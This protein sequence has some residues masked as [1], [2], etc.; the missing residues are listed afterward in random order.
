MTGVN[1]RVNA[2]TRP[3]QAELGRLN[4]SLGNLEAQASKIQKTFRN[5]GLAI[6]GAFAATQL[7]RGL[8]SAADSITNLNNRLALVVGKGDAAAKTL[9][10]LF[11]V[12]ADTRSSIDQSAETFQR[13]GLALKDA[14]KNSDDFLKITKL[15]NQ[16]AIL[17][18]TGPESAKAAIIQLGQGLASG[19]LRGQELNSVLE[20]TPRL[21][22]AIADGMGIPFGSL[23]Q[24]AED[25]LLTTQTVFDAIIDQSQTLGDEFKLMNAT[26]GDLTT[27]LGNE[28]T[29]A[30]AKV[31]GV[32]GF[33]DRAKE[34]IINLTTAFRFVGKNVDRFALNV[35]LAYLIV[36]SQTL[37]LVHNIK[38]AFKGLFSTN[39]DAKQFVDNLLSS[40]TGAAAKVSQNIK[41][42]FTLESIA[43][44]INFVTE[45]FDLISNMFPSGDGS[46]LTTLQTFAQN[47]IDI[48]T[49]LW[50]AIV[51]DSWWTGIFDPAHEENGKAAIGNVASWGKNLDKARNYIAGWGVALTKVFKDLWSSI[52]FWYGTSVDYVKNLTFG[53]VKTPDAKGAFETL[54]NDVSA[55]W[56][57]TLNYVNNG[58]FEI[59]VPP[60]FGT[61]VKT[62]FDKVIADMITKWD[63]FAIYIGAETNLHVP[64]YLEIESNFL[65]AVDNMKAKY[66]ELLSKIKES[67]TLKQANTKLTA[68]DDRFNVSSTV[69][70]TTDKV[71]DFVLEFDAAAFK[72]SVIDGIDSV[73]PDLDGFRTAFKET[74]LVVGAIELGNQIKLD[75]SQFMASVKRGLDDVEGALGIAI[76]LAFSAAISKAFRRKSIT[77]AIG[78]AWLYA[79]STLGNSPAFLDSVTKTAKSY[80]DLLVY[81]LTGEG[82]F[83]GRLALGIV[84]LF[85][86]AGEGVA[87]SL[88]GEGFLGDISAPF[89]AALLAAGSAAVISKKLRDK[90]KVVG[91]TMAKN[92]ISKGFQALMLSKIGEVFLD[93]A[94]SP[95]LDKKIRNTG[96]SLGTKLQAGLIIGLTVGLALAVGN[97]IDNATTKAQ[98][99]ASRLLTGQSRDEQAETRAAESL[100]AS[101][102]NVLAQNIKSGYI[103]VENL[104]ADTLKKVSDKLDGTTKRIL[105]INIFNGGKSSLEI[106]IDKLTAVMDEKGIGGAAPTKKQF[107]TGGYVSGAGTGTSDD[108]PAMLSNGEYVIKAAA[109]DKLGKG[110]LD[111]LNQGILP[112]FNTGG[113]VGR[114]RQEI[115]DSFG[116][117]DT[118]TAMRIISVLEQLGKLDETMEGL[119][120]ATR[121]Q[122]EALKDGSG[123]GDG[124]TTV[125]QDRAA[126]TADQFAS[127]FQ[128]SL[129]G[130]LVSGDFQGMLDGLLDT[131]TMGIID[132]FTAGF[133]DAFLKDLD[134][135]SLFE[136]AGNAGGSMGGLGGLTSLFGGGASGGGMG[137]LLSM[138]MSLFGFSQGGTVPSTPYSQAGKDSVP[139]ML[140]PGEKVLSKND[141]SRMDSNKSTQQSFSIN[142]QGDVSR[143]TRQE[144]IKMIPQITS[145]V[146][147]NNREQGRR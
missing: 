139:A 101:D 52:T 67:E 131:F 61:N 58:K 80:T 103:A 85:K 35:K 107:A 136:G 86:A 18:S 84:N 36:K 73:K 116:R 63:D 111:L 118:D 94:T 47:I 125:V 55:T 123:G 99:A 45:K 74:P 138:G 147:M 114:G 24:A 117:G 27:V 28:F 115:K 106:A 21:A 72:Q 15:V 109:V 121:E 129:S 142:V 38:D 79:A 89:I 108:I 100:E 30:L 81:T 65:L 2:N 70:E 1:I 43:L 75:S 31:D 10:A 92:I 42:Q 145:G 126:S 83:V 134:F 124:E 76:S 64:T 40:V 144:V 33:S 14:G 120:E 9:D 17:S 41:D 104:S 69:N 13:F 66:D 49:N 62:A 16:A 97:A 143:Q 22:K 146:N 137:G 3:A 56:D 88:F 6:S 122:V 26:V 90:M 5:V 78:G 59:T 8:N 44:K 34:T 48:F 87:D 77:L 54:F 135:G 57:K 12:A 102:G 46:I 60:S 105:D 112:R 110:K 93:M 140:M 50:R 51:G 4:R 96:K 23:R 71:K 91:L 119:D 25:G 95:D 37:D 39:F 82:D 132:N 133:T 113:F 53:E 130:A 128:Q 68:L 20:Q 98:N 127:A 7:T 32:L 19:Q 29:R 141:V 11:V